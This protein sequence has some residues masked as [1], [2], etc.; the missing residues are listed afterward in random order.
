VETPEN[1]FF[2]LVLSFGHKRQRRRKREGRSLD[3]IVGFLAKWQKS[4]D[5]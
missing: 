4:I 5:L 2:L 3:K 1:I